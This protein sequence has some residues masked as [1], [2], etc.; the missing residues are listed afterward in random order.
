MYMYLYICNNVIILPYFIVWILGAD[1]AWLTPSGR[2]RQ[3]RYHALSFCR[4][5]MWHLWHRR[6][7]GRHAAR[8]AFCRFVLSFPRPW[9][10]MSIETFHDDAWCKQMIMTGHANVEAIH[11]YS[12]MISVISSIW[13]IQC[14]NHQILRWTGCSDVP[15]PAVDRFKDEQLRDNPTPV[16][17]YSA[18][19]RWM[20]L[21][22]FND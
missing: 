6:Q 18:G 7:C 8:V 20:Q 16:T 9:K 3:E 21:A 12:H 2:G 19:W 10:G 4:V 17:A 14:S 13:L 15:K 5:F 11:R 1:F 22:Y